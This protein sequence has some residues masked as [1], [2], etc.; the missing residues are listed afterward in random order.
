M[1]SSSRGAYLIGSFSSAFC[2]P[3]GDSVLGDEV[4]A[5]PRPRRYKCEHCGDVIFDD[6]QRVVLSW[7]FLLVARALELRPP[8]LR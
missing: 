5:P 8:S 6:Y 2:A 7:P 3:L 4:V 1:T